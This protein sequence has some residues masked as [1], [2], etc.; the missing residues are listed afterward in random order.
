M[1]L[2]FENRPTY[3][4]KLS[5]LSTGPAWSD[6][7]F[8]PFIKTVDPMVKYEQVYTYRSGKRSR[9]LTYAQGYDASPTGDLFQDLQN[10][11]QYIEEVVKDE[12]QP[13]TGSTSV[14]S[15]TDTGHPFASYKVYTDQPYLW[16]KMTHPSNGRLFA[17]Y[18]GITM[19]MGE[20]P[21]PDLANPF[22]VGFIRGDSRQRWSYF[23]WTNQNIPS[24][25]WN[26]PVSASRQIIT[27]SL[28]QAM[29]SGLIAS[30]NPWAPQASLA[31]TIMELLTGDVP[32]VLK[33][34]R[35]YLTDLQSLRR[36]AGSDWLNVQFG[37][38]PLVS[39]I[40]A[41][42]NVLYRLHLLLHDS[43]EKRRHR[44]GDLGTWARVDDS[45]PGIDSRGSWLGSP[46]ANRPAVLIG[47]EGLGGEFLNGAGRWSRTYKVSA[48]YRFAARFHKGIVPNST[49]LGYVDRAVELLGLEITPDVLWQLTPWTWLLDWGTNLGSISKN[50]TNLQWSNVLLDYAYLTFAVKTEA[51]VSMTSSG[52]WFDSRTGYN[53][54]SPGFMSTRV[55]SEEKI[56]EQASP[57]GFSVSW[58]GLSPFQLSILAALGMSRGR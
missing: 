54:S 40:I 29:G 36:T 26:S 48:D 56:R 12:L 42:V 1:P 18:E 9:N 37:W 23:N 14:F 53:Y 52:S 5:R 10:R 34:L 15:T 57:Y 25:W 16:M 39:D 47:P 2:G 49:E 35:R 44:S 4:G 55:W 20:V 31:V 13:T 22:G 43:N 51:S 11:K 27:P 28:K 21:L 8:T 33:N 17:S 45:T 58:D 24:G 46:L 3:T 7:G 30:T 41:A 6:R 50:L 32:S 19:P 38:V